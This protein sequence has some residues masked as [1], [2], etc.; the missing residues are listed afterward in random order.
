[1]GRQTPDTEK[2]TG[3]MCTISTAG[4]MNT[5]LTSER[6]EVFS[7]Y[8]NWAANVSIILPRVFFSVL[9][10]TPCVPQ[11]HSIYI[12]CASYFEQ[13]IYDTNTCT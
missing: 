11:V 12:A 5:A 9:F 10:A 13:I 6:M 7:T 8:G 4:L 2:I 3:N 1:M